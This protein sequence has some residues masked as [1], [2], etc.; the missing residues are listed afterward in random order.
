MR[1]AVMIIAFVI[2]FC[3]SRINTNKRIRD[4]YTKKGYPA[5]KLRWYE[6]MIK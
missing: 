6:W 5:P 2:G 1:I 4:E 3:A